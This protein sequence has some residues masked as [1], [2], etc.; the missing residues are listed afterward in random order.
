MAITHPEVI[1][2][3]TSTDI[4]RRQ[5]LEALQ[6]DCAFWQKTAEELQFQ[7]E[8]IFDAAERDGAVVLCCRNKSVKLAVEKESKT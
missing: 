5:Q 3:Q 2:I 8:K 7:I 4:R 6:K 1:D